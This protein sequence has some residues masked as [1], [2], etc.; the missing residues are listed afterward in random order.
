LAAR[1][2]A[3]AG[4]AL[5]GAAVAAVAVAAAAAAVAA[6]HRPVA[7]E[8]PPAAAADVS[9]AMP[10]Q[11]VLGRGRG[12]AVVVAVQH[13]EGAAV[14]FAAAAVTERAHGAASA[15]TA[16]AAAVISA[17]RTHAEAGEGA[18]AGAVIDHV[19]ESWYIPVATDAC[20]TGGR[21]AAKS[22]RDRPPGAA[23]RRALSVV[24][25]RSAAVRRTLSVAAATSTAVVVVVDAAAAAAVAPRPG[26]VC[27]GPRAAAVITDRHEEDAAAVAPGVEVRATCRREGHVVW[28]VG[29]RRA[30]A[31]LDVPAAAAAVPGPASGVVAVAST[32]AAAVIM[33]DVPCQ[34]VDV[35]RANVV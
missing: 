9:A 34:H 4:R 20:T 18:D 30:P 1:G 6:V 11:C 33:V 31:V 17:R 13:H 10:W 28:V 7:M 12:G 29:A 35:E 23:G 24:A 25:A 27:R 5:P 16:A 8:G 3:L 22:V 2:G 21:A 15:A 14:I 19:A 26:V 32:F